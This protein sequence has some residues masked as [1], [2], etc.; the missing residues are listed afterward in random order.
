MFISVRCQTLVMSA[1]SVVFSLIFIINCVSK[2]NLTRISW[3]CGENLTGDCG[4]LLHVVTTFQVFSKF[5]CSN[6]FSILSFDKVEKCCFFYPWAVPLCFRELATNCLK[7]TTSELQLKNIKV[8][9]R[10]WPQSRP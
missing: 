2:F 9:S 3:F 8:Q 5:F 4:Q 7:S 10:H 1:M 6:S